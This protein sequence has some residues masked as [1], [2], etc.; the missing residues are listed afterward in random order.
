MSLQTSGVEH[1]EGEKNLL[2]K[3]KH[4]QYARMCTRLQIMVVMNNTISLNTIIK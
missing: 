3:T 2:D 4:K 1:S